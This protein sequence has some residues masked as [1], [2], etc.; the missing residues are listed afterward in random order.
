M[1]VFVKNSVG[2]TNSFEVS[3]DIT[4]GK[5]K[6]IMREQVGIPIDNHRLAFEGKQLH[7]DCTLQD[8]RITREAVLQISF[9]HVTG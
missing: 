9:E 6:A 3:E 1:R 2:A 7:D 4:I 5:I 8:Y